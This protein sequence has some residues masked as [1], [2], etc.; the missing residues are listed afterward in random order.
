MALPPYVLVVIFQIHVIDFALWQSL[1]AHAGGLLRRCE[2]AFGPARGEWR[3]LTS[4]N[5]GR[6]NSERSTVLL[7]F[8]PVSTRLLQIAVLIGIVTRDFDF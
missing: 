1:G 7:N 4:V 8:L 3:I 2:S 6:A 5:P